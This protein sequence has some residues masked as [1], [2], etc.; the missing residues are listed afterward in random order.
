MFNYI[1]A[2]T[3]EAVNSLDIKTDE[4]SATPKVKCQEESCEHICCPCKGY[5]CKS[6]CSFDFFGYYLH[7]VKETGFCSKICCVVKLKNTT[8]VPEIENIPYGEVNLLIHQ[9]DIQIVKDYSLKV[10]NT[11]EEIEITFNEITTIQANAFKGF[12]KLKRLYLNDNLISHFYQGTFSDLHN[13]QYLTVYKNRL[14]FVSGFNG[15]NLLNSLLISS[16]RIMHLDQYSFCPCFHKEI[17]ISNNKFNLA[18]DCN[19]KNLY[20]IDLSDN[21][22]T[23]IAQHSFRHMSNLKILKLNK[24]RLTEL[25]NET[26]EGNFNLTSLH[27]SKNGINYLNTESFPETIIQLHLDGNKLKYLKSKMFY[28][29]KE[30]VVLS[31][32]ENDISSIDEDTFKCNTKLKSIF[33]QGNKITIIEEET[34]KYNTIIQEL[35]LL[36]NNIS[37]CNWLTQLGKNLRVLQLVVP[38][39]SNNS[40]LQSLKCNLDE[41][42]VFQVVTINLPVFKENN[43]YHMLNKRLFGGALKD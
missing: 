1:T 18:D 27:L 37:T 4:E 28:K 6:I 23:T 2:L 22:L 10:T 3:L 14:I 31:L 19:G 33:L 5:L 20:L 42:L 7:S 24:N 30:L 25:N 9:T 15:L 16:N 12:T 41:N 29:M 8:E 40:C 17:N 39:V 11:W 26:F 34:F 36:A 13:L 21:N 35:N 32:Y 38:C 43:I